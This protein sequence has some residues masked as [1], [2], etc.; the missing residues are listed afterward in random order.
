MKKSL[1]LLI[2]MFLV[3]VSVEAQSIINIM[4]DDFFRSARSVASKGKIPLSQIVLDKS[5][6]PEEFQVDSLKVLGRFR[7]YDYD[8]GWTSNRSWFLTNKQEREL[9][10]KLEQFDIQYGRENLVIFSIGLVDKHKYLTEELPDGARGHALGFRRGHDGVHNIKRLWGDHFPVFYAGYKFSQPHRGVEYVVC[11]RQRKEVG[12]LPVIPLGPMEPTESTGTVESKGSGFYPYVIYNFD[13]L[14]TST[15]RPVNQM[16]IGMGYGFSADWYG[17]DVK[18]SPL[19]YRRERD[20]Y[21][22]DTHQYSAAA[23]HLSGK[24]T[25]GLLEFSGRESFYYDIEETFWDENILWGEVALNPWHFRLRLRGETAWVNFLESMRLSPGRMNTL[26]GR[27]GFAFSSP[28][29]NHQVELGYQITV[30]K[31]IDDYWERKYNP[32]IG[33]VYLNYNFAKHFYLDF[34]WEKM[35]VITLDKVLYQ[36][37]D[38]PVNIFTIRVLAKVYL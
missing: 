27:A 13:G 5:E 25:F 35:D 9:E 11:Q 24:L 26:Q 4:S 14:H 22:T 8:L 12:R 16:E 1:V 38:P 19:V 31:F 10:R 30:A 18:F 29:E 20:Y 6:I 3:V 2:W 21:L 28:D 23:V 32:R 17:V 15:T 37:I 7:V 34:S 36:V 33:G